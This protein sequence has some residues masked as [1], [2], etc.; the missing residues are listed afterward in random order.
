MLAHIHIRDFAIVDELELELRTGMIALTGETGAGKSILV[1]AVGLAL[2]DRADTTAIRPGGTRADISVTFDLADCPGALHWLAERDLDAGSECVIR[3]VIATEA[4]SR[5]YINGQPQPIQALRELGDHLV[6]IHGQH[7]HQSLLRRDA[8][9]QLLDDFAGHQNRLVELRAVFDQ[10]RELADTVDALRAAARTRNERID[11]LRFQVRELEALGLGPGELEALGEE[12]RRLAHAGRLLD[13]A[14]ATVERLYDADAVSA[15][16]LLSQSAKDLGALVEFDDRL[17]PIAEGLGSAL[18]QLEEAVSALRRY[19]TTLDLDPARLTWL[20]QRLADIV[21]LAR[22]HRIEPESLSAHLDGLQ[23][24]LGELEG[25]GERL[26]GL[27]AELARQAQRYRELAAG[28]SESRQRAAATL[29]AEV[30]AIMH[31]LGMGGGRFEIEIIQQEGSRFTSHGFDEIQF[32]VTANP[33]QPLRPLHKVA[34]GGELSRI[35][36]AIQVI[37]ANALRVPTLVFDEVDAG[38]GGGVAEVVGRQLRA[39]GGRRQVL[40]VTHLPQVAA[41]AHAH[42]FV[43]KQAD[44]GVTRTGITNLSPDRRVHEIARMLGGVELTRQTLAHASEM[45]ERAQADPAQG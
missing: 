4:R 19:A 1:D 10:W 12:Q 22:K 13:T 8:Q 20:E 11:L 29:G 14:Q 42:L 30:T 39:L 31:Q 3:R 44:A 36:L 17:G 23:A 26:D 40:C 18:V 25:A 43:S 16:D 6:D 33:G 7:E 34:S 38:I 21:D 28:L 24:E 9:R 15:H 35:G 37:T 5:G 45:I 2:G 27:E 41:Q 32:L